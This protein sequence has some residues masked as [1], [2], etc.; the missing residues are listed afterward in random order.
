MDENYGHVCPRCAGKWQ[1]SSCVNGT[2]GTMPP[3]PAY[4]PPHDDRVIGHSDTHATYRFY[5]GASAITYTWKYADDFGSWV[6]RV[7]EEAGL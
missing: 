5:P 4:C 2:H 3:A 7:R 1:C 6:K